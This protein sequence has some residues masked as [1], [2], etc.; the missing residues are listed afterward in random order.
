[1]PTV[2]DSPFY[3]VTA[4]ALIFQDS[5]LL[6]VRSIKDHWEIPGGGWEH[7]E[8]FETCLA[9]EIQEELGVRI[10]TVGPVLLM[11]KGASHRHGFK[12]LRITASV[13]LASHEFMLGDD[14][15]EYRFV[16]KDEFLRLDM[17]HAEGSVQ[18]YVDQIWSQVEK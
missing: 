8:T 14:M 11:Y 15:Q 10:Q 2:L 4:K 7:D 13:E 16:D 12:T 18:E 17:M 5:K 9:R 3:R 1:M 6:L